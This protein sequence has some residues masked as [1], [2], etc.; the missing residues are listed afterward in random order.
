MIQTR[1]TSTSGTRGGLLASPWPMLVKQTQSEF[2][3]LA[4][5]PGFSIVSL[6]LP[7]MFFVFFGLTG[8]HDRYQGVY[9]GQYL[10]AS[11]ATYGA[12]SVMLFSFGV[13]VAVERGQRMNVL[14]RATPLRPLVYLAAKV[15]TA[16]VFALA[17]LL[18]LFVVAF[19][20]GGVH[21]EGVRWAQLTLSLLV[22][23]IPFVAL[24]FAIGFV[25]TP[26][27]AAPVTNLAYLILA[28]A[29]GL[30]IPITQLP[31]FIQHLAPYLPVYRLAQVAWSSVGARTAVSLSSDLLWLLG[32]GVVFIAIALRAYRRDEQKTFG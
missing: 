30:F 3:K 2:L 4:R 6:L 7:T 14:T 13:S 18:V 8:G 10:L 28:F 12:I 22:G 16:L 5:N 21:M 9:V 26:T 20:V 24:G 29:S 32:Y 23:S 31:V 15:V 17:M 1:S 19:L 27:A 11:Y 25:A